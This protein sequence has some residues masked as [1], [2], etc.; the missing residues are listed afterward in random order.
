MPEPR[1]QPAKSKK[2]T[3]TIPSGESSITMMRKVRVIC[4]DPYATDSSSSEDECENR[5]AKK[6]KKFIREINLPLVLKQ[7][8][9][10]STLES[11]SSCQDSNNNNG[12]KTP[13]IVEARQKKRVLA[14]TPSRRPSSSKYR[15]VRQRKW[16]KWAAEIRDPF[17]GARIWLG[18]Y[19]TPEEASEAY[20]RKRLE[21]EAAMALSSATPAVTASASSE[22]SNNASTSTA[23]VSPSQNNQQPVSSEDSEGVLSHTSPASVLELETSASNTKG[24]ATDFI[25]DECFEVTNAEI[26]LAELQIPDDLGLMDETFV[27]V[28]F[29]QEL[30]FE[31]ESE[32]DPLCFD[33]IGQFFDGYSG[34]EDIEICGFDNDGPSE[35]PDWDFADIGND[36]ADIGNDIASW[37]DEPLN[38]P[39]Q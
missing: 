13:N 2:S 12:T 10:P 27:D 19:N 7:Q 24:N 15:G 5:R 28:P 26:S 23:V 6:C 16:G 14:K 8:S 22:K 25:T 9:K 17:K 35:L 31:P 38:I 20:E 4:S 33:N 36:F 37:M 21:F 11:E 29:E 18:T 1:K 30:N 32:F 3:A 39:C 34:L